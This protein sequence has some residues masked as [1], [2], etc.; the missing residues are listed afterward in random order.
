MPNAEIHMIS[1]HKVLFRSKLGLELQKGPCQRCWNYCA[2]QKWEGISRW[3]SARSIQWPLWTFIGGEIG[4]VCK[5]MCSI[6]QNMCNICN[7]YAKYVFDM[8]EICKKYKKYAI[9]CK[10]DAKYIQ[11]ICNWIIQ[12]LCIICKKKGAQHAKN[13]QRISKKYAKI[14]INVIHMQTWLYYWSNT[15]INMQ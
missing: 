5:L 14:C 7:I 12:E 11:N 13:M 3:T 2:T 4:K 1:L 15:A 10:I 6:C 9:I 8:Q